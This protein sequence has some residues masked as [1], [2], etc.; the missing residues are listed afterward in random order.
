MTKEDKKYLKGIIIVLILI[1]S[2]FA[3]LVFIGTLHDNMIQECKCCYN[4]GC[5]SN[6]ET[7]KTNGQ[8]LGYTC[9]EVKYNAHCKSYNYKKG[10]NDRAR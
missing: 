1:G 7:F 10:K 6:C 9:N 5:L 4:C 3:Y 8:I 2:Y